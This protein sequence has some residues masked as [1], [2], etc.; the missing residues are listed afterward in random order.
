MLTVLWQIPCPS[1]HGLRGHPHTSQHARNNVQSCSLTAQPV[2]TTAPL[3][4][5]LGDPVAALP[6]LSFALLKYSRHVA[7]Y[8]LTAGVE[9]RLLRAHH[10]QQAT[11][12]LSASMT[13]S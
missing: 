10:L 7:A 8:C 13:A 11:T 9:V 4:L 1:L 12:A 2:V 3:R 5:M 6:I